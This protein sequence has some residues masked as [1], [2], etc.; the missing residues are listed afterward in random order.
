MQE[1][2]SLQ[3]TPLPA[4]RRITEHNW[5][6]ATIPLVS[7]RCITYN[8]VNFIRDAIEGFLMQETTFP[9]EIIIHDD[10]S[11]DGTANIVHEYAKKYPSIIVAIC[12]KENQYS[13]GIKPILH[14]QKLIR[15]VYIATCEGDDYWTDPNKLQIQVSYL[16]S[17]PECVVSGHDA[18]I[19]D[20]EGRLIASSKLPNTSKR[21]FTAQ[22]MMQG[23]AWILTMSH[24]YRNLLSLET[25]P[26]L[27]HIKN[28]DIFLVSVLGKY[29][30]S[31]YHSEIKPACYRQHQGGIWSM[32]SDIT[33]RNDHLNSWFWIYRYWERVGNH[34]IAAI[35]F[36]RW[37]IESV[38]IAKFSILIS[39]LKKRLTNYSRYKAQLITI[40]GQL[41]QYLLR[42]NPI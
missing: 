25:I 22:E 23:S 26:E 37:S 12:Q 2:S 35:W 29:G 38:K 15:G 36:R 40:R 19:V 14:I 32:Q 33:R 24:I 5:D 27:S 11:T 18:F 1:Q 30:S 16:N 21:D 34:D 7:I 3:F 4:P 8:H 10:A 20:E 9:V 17:H 6:P 31:K 41:M 13:K 39:E 42:R 28:G